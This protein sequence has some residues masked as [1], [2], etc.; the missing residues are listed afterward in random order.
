MA[1]LLFHN[2]YTFHLGNG[3]RHRMGFQL[4]KMSMLAELVDLDNSCRSLFE[5]DVLIKEDVSYFEQIISVVERHFARKSFVLCAK[6]R[7]QTRHCQ[8]K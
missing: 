7:F 3:I 8:T 6:K 2:A 1:P 5:C 4:F